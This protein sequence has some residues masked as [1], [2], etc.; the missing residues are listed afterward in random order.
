MEM[1]EEREKQ[2]YII[3]TNQTTKKIK[4]L[5]NEYSLKNLWGKISEGLTL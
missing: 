4:D 1:M 2:N 3:E 5:K